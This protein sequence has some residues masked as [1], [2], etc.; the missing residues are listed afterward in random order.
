MKEGSLDSAGVLGTGDSPDDEFRSPKDLRRP[1]GGW[2]SAP[3]SSAWSFEEQKAR[4]RENCSGSSQEEGG[5]EGDG[6]LA[7][8]TTTEGVLSGWGD[9]SGEETGSNV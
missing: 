9:P 6:A 2:D 1:R 8:T 5:E 7:T 4:E 3:S